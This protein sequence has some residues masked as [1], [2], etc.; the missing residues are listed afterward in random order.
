[1]PN[2]SCGLKCCHAM[3]QLELCPYFFCPYFLKSGLRYTTFV[4]GYDCNCYWDV[5]QICFERYGEEYAIRKGECAG[6]IQSD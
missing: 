6:H 3:D 1:M 4:S 2:Q 5:Y